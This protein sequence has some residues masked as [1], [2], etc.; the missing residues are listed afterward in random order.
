MELRA[1]NGDYPPE[2]LDQHPDVRAG[3]GEGATESR[4]RYP[5]INTG[6]GWDLYSMIGV[7]APGT[8]HYHEADGGRRTAWLLHPDGSWARAT[9]EGDELPVVRQGGPRRLWDLV[10]G[11]R[12]AWLT[13]GEVPAYG[14]DV[15]IRPGGSILLAKGSWQAEITASPGVA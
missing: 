1:A 13:E 2:L 7:T 3:E 9:A 14:A 12:G 4:G 8:Q 10:D 6:F 5:V 11:I 15:T